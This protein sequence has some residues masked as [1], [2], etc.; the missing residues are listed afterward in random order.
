MNISLDKRKQNCLWSWLFCSSRVL[1]QEH[2][3][4]FCPGALRQESRWVA[5]VLSF[6]KWEKDKYGRGREGELAEHKCI[7]SGI[8]FREE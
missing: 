3:I 5:N 2:C 6:T 4:D 1:S 8:N 7:L